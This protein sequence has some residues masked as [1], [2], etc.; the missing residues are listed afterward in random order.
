MHLGEFNWLQLVYSL[1]VDFWWFLK[2]WVEE[3][4]EIDML[5]FLDMYGM[6]WKCFGNF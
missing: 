6:S 2:L 4:L 3:C 1:N 5:V